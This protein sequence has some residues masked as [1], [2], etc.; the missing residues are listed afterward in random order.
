M[1]LGGYC[2]ILYYKSVYL[3]LYVKANIFFIFV[4]FF[5]S[6]VQELWVTAS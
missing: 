2:T 1:T 3:S 5:V 4:L 6:S